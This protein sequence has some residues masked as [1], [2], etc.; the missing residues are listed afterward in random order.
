LPLALATGAGAEMRRSLGTA[1]FWGMLGVTAFGVFL[2]PVFFFVLGWL[3]GGNAC[4]QAQVEPTE[5]A[6]STGITGAPA[7]GH[8]GDPAK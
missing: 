3:G 1:V 4:V 6:V 7:D 2:T 5:G 8:H